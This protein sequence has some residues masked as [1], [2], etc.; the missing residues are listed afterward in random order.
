NRPTY[1]LSIIVQ[2]TKD[3]DQTLA[4]LQELVAIAPADLERFR[5]AVKQRRHPFEPVPLRYRLTE[6][7][8]A[9]LAINEFLLDG[10]EVDAQ[11]VRYY[12]QGAL[13]A[14]TLGYTARIS[15]AD[16]SRFSEEQDLRYR[17]T[18]SIGK[19]GIEYQYED[20][21]HGEVGS[22]NVETNARGRVL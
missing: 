8:I 11:L 14:H 17:G 3:L 21:L 9:R 2:R 5:R 6:E 18:H 13:F 4:L 16:L 12:P 22:Q 15:E 10:V 7:E 1:T 20:L 19:T